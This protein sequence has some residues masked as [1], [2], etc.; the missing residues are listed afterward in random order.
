MTEN[1]CV[2]YTHHKLGDIIWQLPYIK[3]ISEH[4]DQKVDL[5]VRK[6]TQCKNILK[7]LNHIHTIN[8]NDFRKGIYYWVDVFKLIRIFK[9][10]I[11]YSRLYFR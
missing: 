8:Y 1:I 10:K 7:D 6:K 5:I 11:L 3:A 2:V 4:H 9:K